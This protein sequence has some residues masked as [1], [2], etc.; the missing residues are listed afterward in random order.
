MSGEDG[1]SK[2]ESMNAYDEVGKTAHLKGNLKK[3]QA[4]MT[5]L[6]YTKEQIEIAGSDAYNY[7][8]VGNPHI[9]AKIQPGETVLDLGSGLGIDSFIACHYTGPKGQVTAL[10]I[11]KNEIKHCKD[12]ADLR[13]L[14]NINFVVADMEN[15]TL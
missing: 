7:Q 3:A 14:T 2:L 11:S 10:D 12:R 13:K 4:I 6:G 15:M 9:Y 8:G 1:Q 5:Y